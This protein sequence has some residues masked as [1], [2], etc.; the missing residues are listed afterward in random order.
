MGGTDTTEYIPPTEEDM[1]NARNATEAKRVA[2]ENGLNRPS[3]VV[4]TD[5]Y[6]V[7]GGILKISPATVLTFDPPSDS[8]T[9]DVV[10]KLSSASDKTISYK[11][12]TNNIE[13]YRVKPSLGIITP[14][15]SIEINVVLLA[16]FQPQPTDKFL[17][18]AM[19]I[20]DSTLS[21]P[22]LN[23]VWK[24]SPSR[25][26]SDHKLK[27]VMKQDDQLSKEESELEKSLKNI[28]SM[29]GNLETKIQSLEAKQSSLHFK[30]VIMLCLLVF[31]I[32]MF[33]G[34]ILIGRDFSLPTIF[35]KTEL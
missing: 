14:G 32:F 9:N 29:L 1:K 18:M 24:S 7:I 15:S 5:D 34:Q 10:I 26:I 12:K 22:A 31:L 33:F 28:T 30:Q 13:S 2:T 6:T 20:N 25:V 17:I 4:I 11:V 19:E 23:T 21:I 35:P 3:Q 27:C 8:A 16:G